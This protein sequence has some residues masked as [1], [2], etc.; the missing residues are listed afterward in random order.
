MQAHH[1][2]GPLLI[3]PPGGLAKGAG[4]SVIDPISSP[5]PARR[6]ESALELRVLSGQGDVPA[7]SLRASFGPET[8]RERRDSEEMGHRRELELELR[9]SFHNMEDDGD[10]IQHHTPIEDEPSHEDCSSRASWQYPGDHIHL[11]MH[12]N[13]HI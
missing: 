3:S 10:I 7:H 13:A 5:Q 11:Q 4:L 2:C 6:S 9:M 8:P 12:T 1:V